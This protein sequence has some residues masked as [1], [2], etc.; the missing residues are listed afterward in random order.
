M[1]H[2]VLSLNLW[3]WVCVFCARHD[4]AA[5]FFRRCFGY[6]ETHQSR[7]HLFFYADIFKGE[8]KDAGGNSRYQGLILTT[9]TY[10][11]LEFWESSVFS[12][13]VV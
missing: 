9:K 5:S 10:G 4:Q 13:V 11:F 7:D 6:L 2:E 1:L 8:K 3:G 12:D